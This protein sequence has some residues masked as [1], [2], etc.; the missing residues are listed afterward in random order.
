MPRHMIDLQ[1]L[2]MAAN[3]FITK[4]SLSK[5]IKQ[6]HD[7]YVLDVN[8]RPIIGPSPDNLTLRIVFCSHGV[9]MRVCNAIIKVALIF[10]VHINN[11]VY[12]R[13]ISRTHLA[14][15]T[16]NAILIPPRGCGVL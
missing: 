6:L 7:T 12:C 15:S 11:C 16:T 9:H 14:S 3:V 5:Q 4:T 10:V 8:C 2:V 1:L 13:P